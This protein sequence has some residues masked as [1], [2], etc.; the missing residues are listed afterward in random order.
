MR[1]LGAVELWTGRRFERVA[2]YVTRGGEI[3][4]PSGRKEPP[5]VELAAPLAADPYQ[6]G[7]PVPVEEAATLLRSVGGLDRYGLGARGT[8]AV[9]L[10]RCVYAGGLVAGSLV[11][12]LVLEADGDR[13][14]LFAPRVSLSPLRRRARSLCAAW[15]SG[16]F[17]SFTEWLYFRGPHRGPNTRDK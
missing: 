1:R 6:L 13:A 2:A 17:R 11:P 12:A 15:W 3:L 7:Q 14:R 10:G 4:R 9:H 5:L 16:S 8:A